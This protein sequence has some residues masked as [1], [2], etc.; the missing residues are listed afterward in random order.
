MRRHELLWKNTKK[1]KG[2]KGGFQVERKKVRETER[3]KDKK[4]DREIM[5]M[6]RKVWKNWGGSVCVWERERERN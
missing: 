2:K 6:R 5:I 4:D 1:V 3:K